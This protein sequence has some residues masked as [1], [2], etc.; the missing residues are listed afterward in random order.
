MAADVHVVRAS[1][2]LAEEMAPAM[3][4]S[5][6]AE[7]W[8]AGGQ[9]PQAALVESVMWSAQAYA[10]YFDGELAAIFGV[11]PGAFLGGAGIPWLLGTPVLAR[12]PRT[13]L[14]ASRAF[15]AAWLDE[16]GALEQMVDARNLASLRWLRRL[17]FKVEPPRLWGYERRPFCRVHIERGS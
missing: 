17:G 3:R 11:G 6:V 2:E 4:P 15:V 10:A 9:S 5:D 14:E 12:H 16:Y 1:I 8:A 7:V 13:F